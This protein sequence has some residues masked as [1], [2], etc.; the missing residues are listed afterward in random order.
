M[1]VNLKRDPHGRLSR[2][3]ESDQDNGGNSWDTTLVSTFFEI[4]NT[5]TTDDNL[6]RDA[7]LDN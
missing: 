7:G 5:K 2:L 3:I 4:V 1:M 6:P